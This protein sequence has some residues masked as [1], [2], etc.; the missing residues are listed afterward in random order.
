LQ[1]HNAY[2][3]TFQKEGLLEGI[4][5]KNGLTTYPFN[6]SVSSMTKIGFGIKNLKEEYTIMKILYEISDV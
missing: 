3:Q 5:R 4:I 6:I 2:Y 1:Y